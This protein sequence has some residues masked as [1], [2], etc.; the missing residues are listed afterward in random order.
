TEVL[1]DRPPIDTRDVVGMLK[2]A[3]DPTVR[4]TPRQRGATVP[5]WLET[6]CRRALA[7]DPK[8]RYPTLGEFWHAL[9]L[10]AGTDRGRASQ[11]SP[12]PTTQPATPAQPPTVAQAPMQAALAP[13][14]PMRAQTPP[15]FAPPPPQPPYGMPPAFRPS[16]PMMPYG[17]NPQQSG[18][19]PPRMIPRKDNTILVFVILMVL[20]VAF[21]GTCALA[22]SAC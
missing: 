12:T 4:P 2:A 14:P 15:P 1:T 6:V 7:V 17:Q 19:L 3:T 21:M 13:P 18:W 5:D 22:H 10:G 11:P 20:S 9:T 8:A 16:G